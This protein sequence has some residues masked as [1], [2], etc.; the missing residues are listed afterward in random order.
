ML[1]NVCVFSEQNFIPGLTKQN[2]RIGI[3]K[4]TAPTVTSSPMASDSSVHQQLQQQQQQQHNYPMAHPYGAPSSAIGSMMTDLS[5]RVTITPIMLDTGSA[6]AGSVASSTSGNLDINAAKHASATVALPQ[7]SAI[8][9][10]SQLSD[11]M[12]SASSLTASATA[13][14]STSSTALF[15]Q[16]LKIFS[17]MPNIASIGN[18]PMMTAALTE[19][20]GKL[21][22]LYI[23]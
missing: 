11:A 8:K 5:S 2:R 13:G 22:M 7:A 12:A 10:S 19:Y 18:N 23:R 21:Q 9:S 4:V 14:S 3:S 15:Q 17:Q 16:Y 1:S 20:L 6:A